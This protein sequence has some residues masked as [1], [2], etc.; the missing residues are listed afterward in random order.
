[1]KV[2]SRDAPYLAFMFY[3]KDARISTRFSAQNGI[4]SIGI[5]NSAN[6]GFLREM[7]IRYL[8]L[9][10]QAGQVGN[11]AG[12]AALQHMQKTMSLGASSTSSAAASAL[13]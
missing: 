1:M 2:A 12:Y 7:S 3:N 9:F 8:R 4:V 5:W 6:S 13:S 11:S 10:A